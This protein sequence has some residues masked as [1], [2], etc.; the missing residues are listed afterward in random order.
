MAKSENLTAECPMDIAI[1]I[2]SGKWKIAILWHLTKG[3]VRFNEL[4]R[5]LR[6]IT[7]KTLTLQ[8]RELEKDGMIYRKVYAEVPPRVEYGLTKLGESMKPILTSMCE[9]GKTYQKT[10]SSKPD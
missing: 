4:E 6:N 7:H 1:N 5:L 9:W 10:Y 8:L 3:I 2:L